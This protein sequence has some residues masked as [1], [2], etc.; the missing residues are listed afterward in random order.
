MSNYH[1]CLKYSSLI[2]KAAILEIIE[3]HSVLRSSY[4]YSN[5]ERQINEHQFNGSWFIPYIDMRSKIGK[6]SI[7]NEI[8]N[9][10]NLKEYHPGI[11]NPLSYIFVS[12]LTESKYQIDLII[13][14]CIW[15]KASSQIFEEKLRNKLNGFS[16]KILEST[17]YASY[18]RE[19]LNTTNSLSDNSSFIS[20]I[21][22]EKELIYNILN[23]TSNN[24]LQL[25]K[26]KLFKLGANTLKKYRDNPWEIIEYILQVIAQRNNLKFMENETYPILVVQDER[27]YMNGNYAETLGCFLDL[28]PAAINFSEVGVLKKRVECSQ[29]LKKEKK[30]NFSELIFDR[31]QD[32]QDLFSKVLI[33][34]Y[35][36][37]YDISPKELQNW[38]SGQGEDFTSTEI[39]INDVEDQLIVT[40]PVFEGCKQDIGVEIQRTLDKLEESFQSQL[41]LS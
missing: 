27:N 33:V 22:N 16:Y 23:K 13:D 35:Q 18:I 36:G 20:E 29:S 14:H 8:A 1:Y 21:L 2:I 39:F 15:D 31:A 37:A 9:Y 32:I 5:G 7:S 6:D 24:I 40:Y 10:I 11:K 38:L 17:S 3:E 28:V 34:N 30:I 12:R 4:S 25:N 19:V 41:V 26:N